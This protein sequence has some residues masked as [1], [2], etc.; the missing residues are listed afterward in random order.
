MIAIDIGSNSLRAVQID[1]YSF[2]KIFEYEKI[3]QTA[4]DLISTKKISKIAVDKIV[5]AI[6]EIKNSVD[7]TKDEVKAV[8]TAAF[9]K[10]LNKDEVIEEI[11]LKTGVDVEIIDPDLEGY[12]SAIAAQHTLASFGLEDEKFLLCDIGGGSTEF[13]FKHRDEIVTKS[14]NLGIVTAWERYKNIDQLKIGIKKYMNEI[15]IFLKDLYEIFSKPKRFVAT[16]GT[17]TTIAAIKKGLNY[18]TYDSK[19]VNGTVIFPIDIDNALR[20]LL[21][22]SKKERAK[23]VGEGREDYIIAGVLILKEIMRVA[24]FDEIFVCDDGVR[25]GVA[26]AECKK[27]IL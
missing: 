7:F 16:G 1:C 18:K 6:N 13:V 22:L 15:K 19:I 8:A 20:K 2:K 23:L 11:R 21:A 24:D 25:E 4:Q 3:V 14:F 17:P 10:A 5:E 27:K 12:Y 9:R 26:I